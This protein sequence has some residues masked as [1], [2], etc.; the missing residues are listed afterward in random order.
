[1][2]LK[3]RLAQST[4]RPG[5]TAAGKSEWLALRFNLKKGENYIWWRG[6]I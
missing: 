6:C 3:I 2:R 4:R 5:K 1:M